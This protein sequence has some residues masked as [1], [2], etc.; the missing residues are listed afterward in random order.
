[1]ATNKEEYAHKLGNLVLTTSV[2]LGLLVLIMVMMGFDHH[3]DTIEMR[4]TEYILAILVA[5]VPLLVSFMRFV[6]VWSRD[7]RQ[8]S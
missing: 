2:S 7:I 1:M 4:L 6:R 8:K 3:F 5:F